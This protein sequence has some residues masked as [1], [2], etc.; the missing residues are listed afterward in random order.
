MNGRSENGWLCACACARICV[1][2]HYSVFLI[3]LVS[4]VFLVSWWCVCTGKHQT[5]TGLEDL[6]SLDTVH[7]IDATCH[8]GI[9]YLSASFPGQ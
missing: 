9:I 6:S 7:L 5:T 2:K 1:Q 3:A 8:Q 4:C